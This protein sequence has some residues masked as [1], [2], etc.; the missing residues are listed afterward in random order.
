MPWK[1]FKD[2]AQWC[3]HKLKDDGSKGEK[4]KGGCHPSKADADKH[5]K[6]LHTN[7]EGAVHV[8]QRQVTYEEIPNTDGLLS[9]VRDVE[10]CAVGIEYPL[11]SGPKTFTP[12][13]LLAAIRSQDDPAIKAPRVWLGHPDDDRFHAGRATPAGTAEPALGTVVNMRVEDEGMTLVGDIAGCPTWLAKILASAYPSRSIEGFEGAQTVTGR[14]WDVVITDLALL[15]VRWPGVSTIEDIQLL[16]SEEGPS[17]DVEEAE[18]MSIAAATGGRIQAQ[19]ELEKIRRAFVAQ[20]PD[21]KIPG[22]PWIRSVLQDPN[23]LIVDDDEGGLYRVPY[24]ATGEDVTFGDVKQ[25]Q[26][27]YV[28]AS[29]SRDPDARGLLVNMLTRDSKV[30]ASW[31]KRAESRP[32]S[33][34]QEASSVNPEIIKALRARLGLSEEQLP[35]DAT[36][37][38]VQAA[39]ADSGEN[40]APAPKPPTPNPGDTPSPDQEPGSPGPGSLET[41]T[42]EPVAASA[43][44]PEG[45]VAVPADAWA[46]TQKQVQDIAAARATEQTAADLRTVGDALRAGKIFP[47][48]REYYEGKIKD[49]NTREAFR[50]LLTASVAEGGLAPGIVP[51]EARGQDPS[52]TEANQEAY[53]ADWLPELRGQGST[54]AITVEA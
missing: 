42:P 4:V 45:M 27:Q 25:V 21:L 1:V 37:E 24:D 2:G 8:Q 5:A 26:I 38:Q 23:E 39:L 52:S 43:A 51:L 3:V 20:I 30:V 54:S 34:T 17:V 40:P 18:P 11:A 53:P 15:G 31:G 16:Y 19:A 10:I 12:E 6:A 36:E 9:V 32:D 13:D 47:A 14:E 46:E 48:Q 22:W 28:N 44:L 41:P 35:D 33:E 49:P 7:V 50:H 29:Q